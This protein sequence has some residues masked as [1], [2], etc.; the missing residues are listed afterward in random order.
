MPVTWI[1]WGLVGLGVV[2]LALSVVPLSRRVRPLRRAVRRLSWRAEEVRRLSDRAQAMQDT[3]A[4]LGEQA[5]RTQATVG[6]VREPGR[7]PR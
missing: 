2:V 3:L 1:A 7:G 4:E 6:A 5:A